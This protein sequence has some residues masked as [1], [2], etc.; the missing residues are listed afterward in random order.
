MK[1]FFPLPE[2]TYLTHEDL[3]RLHPFVQR[4]NDEPA[5]DLVK[6]SYCSSPV[7]AL[8]C[9]SCG[10]PRP[11]SVRKNVILVDSRLLQ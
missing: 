2:A 7:S 3:Q 10:A 1:D 8:R 5:L 9:E 4:L 6:C 11:V